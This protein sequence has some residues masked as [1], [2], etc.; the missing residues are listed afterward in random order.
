M[1]SRALDKPERPG[2]V[3]GVGSGVTH[4]TYF[5][6]VGGKRLEENRNSLQELADAKK[7]MQEQDGHINSLDKV[8]AQLVDRL[9][10]LE[11]KVGEKDKISEGLGS[12]SGMGIFN[13]ELDN[14]KEVELVDNSK[15]VERVDISPVSLVIFSFNITYLNY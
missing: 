3:R 5:R 12:C 8:I 9:G 2:R 6:F 15:E 11:A 4:G 14:S 1:L 13:E 10:K 7:K